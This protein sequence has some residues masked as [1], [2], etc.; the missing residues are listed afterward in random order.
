MPCTAPSG[1]KGSQYELTVDD[2]I[3]SEFK[4]VIRDAAGVFRLLRGLVVGHEAIQLCLW[5][6]QYNPSS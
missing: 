3:T 5:K 6:L 4:N 1:N 2:L